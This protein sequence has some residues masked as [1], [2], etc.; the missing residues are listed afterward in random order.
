[1]LPKDL[2]EN[3]GVCSSDV[4]LR[5]NAIRDSQPAYTDDNSGEHVINKVTNML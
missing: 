4:H 2:K 5:L 3:C 1:M